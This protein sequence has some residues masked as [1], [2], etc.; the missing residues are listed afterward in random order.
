MS[1]VM[2]DMREE[3]AKEAERRLITEIA[4]RMLSMGLSHEQVAEGVG[5]TVEQVQD[6]AGMKG[7]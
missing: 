7:V 2:E 3:A 1:K 6:I 5:I 4:L